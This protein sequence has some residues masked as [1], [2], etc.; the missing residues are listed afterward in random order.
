M[1]EP[2]RTIPSLPCLCASVRR[3]SRTLTQHYE[4]ALRP[5]GLRAT[6]FTLLQ[7]LSTAGEVRQDQLAQ[8]LSMD[9]T[10]LTRKLGILFRNGWIA[11]RRGKDRRERLWRLAKGGRGEFNRALPAWQ[12]TQARLENHLGEARWGSLQ[13]ELDG[14][15]ALTKGGQM[16]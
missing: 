10:T 7:V 14:I 15:S 9:S 16:S 1:S 4:N 2:L 5:F 6:Q 12:K 13:R 3:A 8:I 11:R